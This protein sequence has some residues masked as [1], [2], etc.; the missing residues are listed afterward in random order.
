MQ[1]LV[2]SRDRKQGS[3][4]KKQTVYAPNKAKNREALNQ[5]IISQRSQRAT[6]NDLSMAM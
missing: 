1:H 5:S 6:L 3:S 2:R 4:V